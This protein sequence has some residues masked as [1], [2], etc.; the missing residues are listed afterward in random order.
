MAPNELPYLSITEAADQLRRKAVSPVE[1]VQACLSRIESIDDKLHS[2]ITVTAELALEQAKT[3]EQEINSGTNRGPLHGIPIG[4]KDLYATKG[5][6]TTCHSAVLQD[7]VPDQ[8]A[9]TVTK[10]R[11]AGTI[12][13][14]KLGMHE[15]AF[16]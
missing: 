2:F 5:I 8:D 13:L 6:R 3:A 16:G 11:E 10:L 7:W 4:I 1:L 15:F 12:L 14:G 9:T